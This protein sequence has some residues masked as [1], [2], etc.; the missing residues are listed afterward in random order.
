MKKERFSEEQVV[1]ILK[2]AEQGMPVAEVI[3]RAG[4][5]E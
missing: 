3:R 1:S 5:S 4:V 2:Q